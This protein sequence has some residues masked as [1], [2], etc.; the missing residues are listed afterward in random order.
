MQ[1]LP[2]EQTPVQQTSTLSLKELAT[3]LIKHHGY[4]EGFYEIGLQFNIAV[5]AVGPEPSKVSPGAVLTVEGISLASCTETSPLA[6]N[7]ATVN[8]MKRAIP[9]KAVAKK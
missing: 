6:V 1:E 7:A 8:P 5:G 4:H 9:K 2:T 3:I